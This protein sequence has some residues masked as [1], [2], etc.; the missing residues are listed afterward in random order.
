MKNTGSQSRDA[1]CLGF[2]LPV[3]DGELFLGNTRHGPDSRTYIKRYLQVFEA[4]ALIAVLCMGYLL[5][6]SLTPAQGDGLFVDVV[7]GKIFALIGRNSF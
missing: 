3:D 4:M 7:S 5:W 2:K 1:S 6:A